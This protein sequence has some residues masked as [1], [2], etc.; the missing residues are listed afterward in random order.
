[1][2]ITR[3]SRRL[4]HDQ[5]GF[6]LIETLVGIATGL[7]VMLVL[8]GML[9][10]ATN[11]TRLISDKVESDRLGRQ[12]MTRI[13]DELQSACIA[14]EFEPILSRSEGSKLVFVNADSEGAELKSVGASKKASEGVYEHEIVFKPG[15]EATGTLTEYVYPSTSVALPAT[16][17]FAKSPEKTIRIGEHLGQVKRVVGGKEETVPVFEY[18][19]YS[20]KTTTTVGAS[21]TTLE[22]IPLGEGETLEKK[23]KVVS[24]A[25]PSAAGVAINFEQ[26]PA[27][28]KEIKNERELHQGI[29]L[30]SQVT[31]AL[32]SPNTETPIKDAPCN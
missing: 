30:Q 10:V 32:G 20:E 17:E 18:L 25:S 3:L 24:V 4:A 13:G 29:V 16:P 27:R 15:E 5:G 26:T 11:Q 6:T 22:K 7:V 31:L 21:V 28:K 2:L 14:R 9:K 1:M 19:K 23:E 12:V 8:F